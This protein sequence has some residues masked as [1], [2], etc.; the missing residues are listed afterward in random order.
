MSNANPQSLAGRVCFCLLLFAIGLYLWA[1]IREIDRN[2]NR[3]ADWRTYFTKGRDALLRG[4][5]SIRLR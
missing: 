2:L 1:A 3:D 5:G 4:R